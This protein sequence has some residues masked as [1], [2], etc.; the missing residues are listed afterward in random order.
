[1]GLAVCMG[2]TLTCSFGL[3]P[4]VLSVVPPKRA[5]TPAP[6]ATVGDSVP[7]LNVAPFGACTTPSNPAVAAATAAALGVP[8]PAPCVPASVGPWIP[9][10]PHH[11]TNP[12]L[13]VLDNGY[14]LACA[15]SGMITVANPGQTKV[16]L[17]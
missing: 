3:A 10:P 16:T 6:F 7:L 2:A 8:T 11:S 15:W 12:A 17:K 14:R 9:A 13:P 4:S 5:L 1:M